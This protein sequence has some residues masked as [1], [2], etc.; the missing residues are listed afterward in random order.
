MNKKIAFLKDNQIFFVLNTDQ[1]LAYKILNA[2]SVLDVSDFP[3][4][5]DSGWVKDGESFYKETA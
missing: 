4:E 5:L 1:S 3:T 2:D